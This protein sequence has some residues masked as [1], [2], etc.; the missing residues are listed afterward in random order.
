MTTHRNGG[1]PGR[2]VAAVLL[3]LVV[4]LAGCAGQPRRDA[5][6]QDLAQQA[7]REALLA[8]Q[9]QWSLEGRIA[10][11]GGGDGGSGQLRWTQAGAETVFEMRAPV[12]RQTWRLT[13]SPGSVRLDGLDGGPRTGDDAEALLRS[14]LG[15]NLPLSNLASW[16]RGMR[17]PGPARVQLDADGLPAAIEQ[18]GWRIEYRAWDRSTDPAL[19]SRVFAS[20]GDQRVRLAV[21][22]WDLSR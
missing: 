4:L 14:E 20:R 1:L 6:P 8:G 12:S 19:P 21:S 13:A 5:S 22:H 16:V 9:A 15:W 18:H 11:S 7:A 2:S 10:V 17:G 3:S